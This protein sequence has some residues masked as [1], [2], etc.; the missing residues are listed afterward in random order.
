MIVEEHHAVRCVKIQFEKLI[1]DHTERAMMMRSESAF[2]C[3]TVAREKSF[4]SVDRA[5]LSELWR[6]RASNNFTF[7]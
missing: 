1:W 4:A 2:D 5:V 3:F 6:F 7:G